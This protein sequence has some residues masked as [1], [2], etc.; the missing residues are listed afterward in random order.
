MFL[1][2]SALASGGPGLNPLALAPSNMGKV[3]DSLSQKLPHPTPANLAIPTKYKLTL[4]HESQ[5]TYV[6]QKNLHFSI[7]KTTDIFY[8]LDS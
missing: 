2:G 6:C 3:S 4:L 8:S 5:N 7:Q 1:L